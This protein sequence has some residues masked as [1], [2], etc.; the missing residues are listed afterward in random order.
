MANKRESAI[1]LYLGCKCIVFTCDNTCIRS[2]R[3]G[4]KGGNDTG[5]D[6]MN[7]V[8]EMGLTKVIM[9]LFSVVVVFGVSPSSVVDEVVA[10]RGFVVMLPSTVQEEI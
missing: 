8:V 1:I 4:F 10:Q 3:V 9:S 5:C 7:S 2:S 6:C